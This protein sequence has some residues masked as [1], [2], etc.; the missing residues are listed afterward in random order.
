MRRQLT[1][2]G[3]EKLSRPC[4]GLW[5]YRAL[6]IVLCWAET[7][8]L[9]CSLHNQ[10]LDVGYSGKVCWGKGGPLLRQ[11]LKE[12]TVEASTHNISSNSKKSFLEGGQPHRASLVR[13][14]IL[15]YLYIILYLPSVLLIIL[16]FCS[17]LD[18][19]DL[20]SLEFLFYIHHHCDSNNNKIKQ[21]SESIDLF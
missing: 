11:T 6:K 10:S 13:H 7:L 3:Q 8:W 18:I 20:L 17:I 21:K 9:L 14:V 16:G 1:M 2:Q 19:G 4:R 12:W 5:I 15:F